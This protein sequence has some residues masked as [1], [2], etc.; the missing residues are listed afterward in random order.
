MNDKDL[1]EDPELNDEVK[2]LFDEIKKISQDQGDEM[3]KEIEERLGFSLYEF[4]SALYDVLNKKPIIYKKLHPDAEEPSYA[5][6]TDSGFDLI[7]VEQIN[8]GPFERK[9][10]PTG[11]SFNIPEG[12]EIQIRTKSGLALKQGLMVLNS[13]GTIDQGYTGEIKVI[14]M[15]MNN[16]PLTVNKGQ[17]IAQGVLCAVESGKKIYFEETSEIEE[18]DRNDNGFGSTGI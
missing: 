10:V 6:E 3:M 4:E 7:S 16:S 2:S 8:F 9:L 11:L 15:N 14:L 13:P 5:Y 17:K 1:H 12:F 18:K